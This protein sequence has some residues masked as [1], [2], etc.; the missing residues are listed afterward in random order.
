MSP[1]I[2]YQLISQLL[3]RTIFCFLFIESADAVSQRMFLPPQSFKIS[4][5]GTTLASAMCLDFGDDTPQKQMSYGAG[6]ADLGD[7]L[8]S[9]PGRED[10]TVK[11]AIAQ[12]VLEVSGTGDAETL[13]FHSLIAN[14]EIAVSVKRPSVM[15]PRDNLRTS[16]LVGLPQLQ[17]GGPIVD[18]PH[19]WKARASQIAKTLGMDP[20]QLPD[21][22]QI[23]PSWMSETQDWV[24]R[25]LASPP[26]QRA[27]VLQRVLPARIVGHNMDLDSTALPMYILYAGNTAPT[28]FRGNGDLLRASSAITEAWNATGG[29]PPPR[30]VLLGHGETQDF[31]AAR[32]TLE[33]AAGGN[34]RGALIGRDLSPHFEFEPP[35]GARPPGGDDVYKGGAWETL[36]V[37]RRKNDTVSATQSVSTRGRVTVVSRTLNML[38][39]MAAAVRA[40]AREPEVDDAPESVVILALRSAIADEVKAARAQDKTLSALEGNTPSAIISIGKTTTRQVFSDLV[41]PMVSEPLRVAASGR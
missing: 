28:V 7:I 30:V 18:Q 11:D 14:G 38:S 10:L 34:G 12:K 29:P 25:G 4:P 41:S 27:F 26:A 9:V 16:D 33:A 13:R 36:R 17:P 6:P 39:R 37:A 15:L 5:S 23:N 2:R 1:L 31:D 32:M 40:V 20:T 22:Y 24:H 19:L 35:G 8:V 3:L 21:G